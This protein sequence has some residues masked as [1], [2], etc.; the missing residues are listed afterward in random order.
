M[1]VTPLEIQKRGLQ[2]GKIPLNFQQKP[3]PLDPH[4]VVECG[5][6]GSRNLMKAHLVYQNFR[7][8]TWAVKKTSVQ[9]E[10]T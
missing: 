4:H 5:E 6:Q 3:Q 2:A 9:L 7:S 1:G 10:V 8:M